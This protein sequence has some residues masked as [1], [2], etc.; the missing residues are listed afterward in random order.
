MWKKVAKAVT[1]PLIISHD[2]A[3][4]KD[5]VRRW[6]DFAPDIQ[7]DL[8]RMA[9]NVLRYNV[10]IVGKFFNKWSLVSEAWRNE[11]SEDDEDD[12]DGAPEIIAITKERSEGLH[13]ELVPDGAVC[14]AF[15]HATSTWCSVDVR[16]NG[17]RKATQREDQSTIISVFSKYKPIAFKIY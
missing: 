10:V 5:S 14:A 15:G 4:H 12:H 13:S 16:C 9:K 7:V 2:G 6:K 17:N 8:V 3:M 11:Q 1:V